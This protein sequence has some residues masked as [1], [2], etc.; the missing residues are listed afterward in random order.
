LLLCSVVVE[1]C[2]V[3]EVLLCCVGKKCCCVVLVWY[4]VLCRYCVGVG[5]SVVL[6]CCSYQHNNTTL[7]TTGLILRVSVGCLVLRSVDSIECCVGFSIAVF[8]LCW[9][10]V[11]LQTGVGFMVLVLGILLKNEEFF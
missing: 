1:C 10:S 3:G 4:C 8:V 11:F 2:N 7:T 6:L 9:R 5:I